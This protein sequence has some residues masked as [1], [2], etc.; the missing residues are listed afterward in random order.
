M[1][2]LIFNYGD[3]K[4]KMVYEQGEYLTK[5]GRQHEFIVKYKGREVRAI[6]ESELALRLRSVILR[7]EARENLDV[8]E[9]LKWE[10]MSS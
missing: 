2:T 1:Q 3:K 5:D 8:W 9:N 4:Y 7:D 6:T 10:N